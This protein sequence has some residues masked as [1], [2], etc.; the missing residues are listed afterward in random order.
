MLFRF[1]TS[2][3]T[4]VKEWLQTH[5]AGRWN[6]VAATILRRYDR[7][8]A[9]GKLAEMLQLKVYDHLVLPEGLAGELYTLALARVDFYAIGLQLAQAAEAADPSLIRAVDLSDLED[10]V[11]L[12][13]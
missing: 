12:T 9:V 4:G 10:E 7:E 8:I 6:D 5:E 2:E 1:E 13:A 3:T 11:E